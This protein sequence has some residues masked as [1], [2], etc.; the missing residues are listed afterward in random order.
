ML[1]NVIQ[2]AQIKE[3]NKI[4]LNTGGEARLVGGCV[5]DAL[6]SKSLKD[7]DVATNLMPQQIIEICIKNKIKCIPTGIKHGTVTAIISGKPIEITT[8][9][10]DIQCDGRHAVTEFTDKWEVDAARRDFTFNALYCDFNGKIYDY[11]NGISDLNQRQLIFVGDTEQ[12]ICEDYL[13]ILRAFRFH[14]QIGCH[15]LSSEILTAC[16][17]YAQKIN[18]LSGERIRHEM[19]NLLT[20]NNSMKTLKLMKQS[21]VLPYVIPDIHELHDIEFESNDPL[22]NLAYI[23]RSNKSTEVCDGLYKMWRLSK[24]EYKKLYSLCNTDISLHDNQQKQHIRRLGKALYKNILTLY[25]YEKKITNE[26]FTNN[27]NLVDA[28]QV[29]SF[30][31][32]GKDLIEI[33]CKPGADL[34]G[35]LK[36]ANDYWE[37]N[38]YLLKRDELIQYIQGIIKKNHSSLG[39][40]L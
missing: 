9:R 2:Q 5:R 33:G 27:V 39:K 28:W 8:L 4:I 38:N 11:F 20:F 3:L 37:A 21:G 30:P 22:I 34:G 29:P 1:N 12:R 32:T 25:K 23:I 17:K 31:L 13:R 16:Q 26:E 24:Q 40:P 18:N 36:Q 10:K 19:L 14:A 35:Y 15:I 6:L 7:I